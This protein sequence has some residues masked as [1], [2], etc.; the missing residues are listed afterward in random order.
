MWKAEAVFD[1]R[2]AARI[3][4]L[5]LAYIGDAV[6]ELYVRLTLLGSVDQNAGK[7]HK[8]SIG[9]VNAR[10]QAGFARRVQE[11]LTERES[12]IFVRG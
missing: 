10:A 11:R 8:R 3:G 6:F 5:T 12:E 7:L 9:I 2:D 4:P 1:E